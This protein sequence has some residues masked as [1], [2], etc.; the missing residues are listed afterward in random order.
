MAKIKKTVVIQYII[1]LKAI[2]RFRNQYICWGHK[3]CFTPPLY[4]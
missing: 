1:Y 2:D 3:T 4:Y